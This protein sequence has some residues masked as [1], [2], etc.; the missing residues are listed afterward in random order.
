M[1]RRSRDE[2]LLMED[3]LTAAFLGEEELIADE[4]V[5]T[6]SPASAAPQDDWDEEE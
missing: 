5:Q 4:P 1:A 2:D 6:A 3:E